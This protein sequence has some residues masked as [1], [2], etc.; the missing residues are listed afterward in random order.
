MMWKRSKNH[1]AVG[2]WHLVAV[3]IEVGRPH[4]QANRLYAL[5]AVAGK[6]IEVGEGLLPCDL[7]RC[8]QPPSLFH[9]RHQRHVAVPLGNRLF[10]AVDMARDL[11]G[12]GKLGL[13][14]PPV[15]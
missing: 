2:A 6:A 3:G 14:S 1:L 13:G 11:A 9:I 5:S 15:A 7:H 12:L 10:V 4:M 8:I